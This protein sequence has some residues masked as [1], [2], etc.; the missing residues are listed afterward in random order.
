MKSEIFSEVYNGNTL[1]S[2]PK[3]HE[4]NENDE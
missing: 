3:A 2:D 1:F 4:K